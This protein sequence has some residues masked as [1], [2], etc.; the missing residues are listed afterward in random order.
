MLRLKTKEEL[1]ATGWV[2]YSPGNFTHTDTISN[3][4]QAMFEEVKTLTPEDLT[5]IN[6]LAEGNYKNFGDWSWSRIMFVEKETQEETTEAAQEEL[7][8]EALGVFNKPN[9]PKF[10]AKRQLA[11]FKIACLIDQMIL[12][13]PTMRFGQILESLQVVK[14]DALKLPQAEEYN[15]WLREVTI[16]S[17]DIAIRAE[18][19]FNELTKEK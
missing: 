12:Q 18:A 16:E 3:I 14:V 2:E 4:M 17:W 13:Y 6:S 15:I 8:E 5:I 7:I 11:N 19:A 10:D 1:K 9:S